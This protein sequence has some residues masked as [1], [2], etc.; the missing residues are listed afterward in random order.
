MDSQLRCGK[1]RKPVSSKYDK[2]LECGF[3]GPHS[4]HAQE[5]SAVEGG[6]PISPARSRGHFPADRIEK[7]PPH[8]HGDSYTAPDPIDIPVESHPSHHTPDFEDNSRF[9]AGMRS[10]SPILD[11]IDVMDKSDDRQPRKRHDKDSGRDYMEDD[12]IYS[13]HDEDQEE[14]P[15]DSSPNNMV[16][17]IVSVTLI[18][19]LIIAIIYIINNY[20]ELTKWLASPTIPE[21]FKPSQ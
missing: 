3:L 17:I 11:H 10:R 13:S 18:L 5:D 20:E 12:D 14:K 6:I 21:I 7:P 19:L 2:C 9:P 15:L 16:T 8:T 4:F 1:C